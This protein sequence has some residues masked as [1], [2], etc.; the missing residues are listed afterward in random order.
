M[1]APSGN[2]PLQYRPVFRA[3]LKV[4]VEQNRLP[5]ECERGKTGVVVE[6]V[7]KPVNQTNKPEPVLLKREVPGPVPMGMGDNDTGFLGM[8][9]H[10]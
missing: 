9:C 5:V 7:Y 6:Q 8:S 2:E 4:I 1:Q 3:D 10:R